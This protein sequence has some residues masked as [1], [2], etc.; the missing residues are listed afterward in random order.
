MFWRQSECLQNLFSEAKLNN[1]L[2]NYQKK[3]F[4]KY[5]DLKGRASASA[6]D[7]S[8]ADSPT[9]KTATASSFI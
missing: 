8:S 1:T 7:I 9:Q 3:F 2:K 4:S 5:V 6:R